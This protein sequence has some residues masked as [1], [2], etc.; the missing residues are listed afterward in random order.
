MTFFPCHTVLYHLHTN[1]TSRIDTG[2]GKGGRGGGRKRDT[3]GGRTSTKHTL[4]FF[5]KNI[6]FRTE[7]AYSYF[8]VDFRLKNFLTNILSFG[9][10]GDM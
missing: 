4:F 5:Y 7:A 8:L 2:H 3:E 10:I 6:V 1:K 9:N